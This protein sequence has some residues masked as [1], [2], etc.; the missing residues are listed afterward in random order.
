MWVDEEGRTH[1]T[2][3]V[4]S[5]PPS[6]APRAAGEAGLGAL[7]S[8]RVTGPEPRPRRPAASPEDRSARL[9][10]G[11]LDD[12]RRG[13]SARAAAALESVLR[14]DPGHPEAHWYLALLDRERG[15]FESAERHLEAFLARAGDRYEPWR[16]SA[17]RRLAALADERRLA[18]E[19]AAAGPLRLV[20][21]VSP[22]FRIQYDR[23]LGEASPD[24]A[25]TVVRY[26]EEA[27]AHGLQRFGVSPAEPVGVVFYGKAAYLAAHRH[28]FGFPTVGF[29]DGRIHVASAAHPAGELRALLF[30]EYAHALFA[31]CTGGHRPFWLNEGLAELAERASR[32]EEPLSRSERAALRRRIGAGEWI[33]LPRLAGGFA[34]LDEASARLAY[35]E[36]TA[37][38]AWV[39]RRSGPEGIAALL[40]RLGRGED[41]DAALRARLG[42]DSAGVDAALRG[43]LAEEFP[44]AG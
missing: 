33:P 41:V 15:R 20:A 34:G 22:H 27:H 29:F 35:L 4:E 36:S 19:Q 8:G 14:L 10:R 18:A 21:A 31:E 16:A 13:E 3:D 1:V 24:Y 26:L 23:R 39:A 37:A 42:V 17:A 32:G 30:H 28:R 11:A 40:D 7:W 43:E 38:A 44:A 9:V 5:I 6:A 25:Q 12:L 2:D